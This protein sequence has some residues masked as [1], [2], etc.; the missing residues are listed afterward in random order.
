M[1]IIKEDNQVSTPI[2]QN[3]TGCVKTQNVLCFK[4]STPKLMC[5]FMD[6]QELPPL[7]CHYW[8]DISR[9]L[10]LSIFQNSFHTV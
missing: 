9:D 10:P 6:K 4:N 1:E 3:T 8:L 2:S 5:F 7:K